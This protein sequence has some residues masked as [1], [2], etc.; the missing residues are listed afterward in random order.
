MKNFYGAAG[1]KT[2]ESTTSSKSTEGKAVGPGGVGTE[3]KKNQNSF[4][5]ELRQEQ[6]KGAPA[7]MSSEEL[8]MISRLP[9][10][11][12]SKDFGDK[13]Y[14]S[15]VYEVIRNMILGNPLN[16]LLAFIPFAVI[17][18]YAKWSAESVFILNCIALVPLA[19]LLGDF[20][21]EV[22][23]HTNQTIGGLINATFGN[24]FEVVVAIQALMAY[25]IRIVQSSMLGSVLSN[26]L[27]V[28]G[29][30]FFFGGMKYKEQT[31]N[32]VKATATMGLLGLSCIAMTLPTPFAH[33]YEADDEEAL[34]I[35][36]IA[37]VA[38]ICMYLQLL[39]FQLFTHP[40]LFEDEDDGDEPE[41][42]FWT[43]VT[44]LFIVTAIITELSDY[45]VQS[46]DGFCES[47]GLSRT[48]VGIIIIPIVGNAIEHFTAVSFAMKNKLDL[49][50]EI[51]VGSSVQISIFVTPFVVVVGWFVDRPLTLNFPHYET[52]LFALSVLIVSSCVS[53]SRT[54]W[55]EGSLL[56]TLYVMIAI[57]F[58]F[59][60][61]DTY[62][63]KNGKIE[64]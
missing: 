10:D 3:N 16:I 1:R 24:A 46:I 48:F 50:M 28:L 57:G 25:E 12:S 42:P 64:E 26:L 32:S 51:C 49:A 4:R 9:G 59:E 56:V 22:A 53:N 44:C 5:K 13:V 15:T 30:S 17:S 41:M 11:K 34:S 19:A 52:F 18:H 21:E 38:L 35:S 58:W 7:S 20:T 54:N 47:S 6:W 63:L 29:C 31:F 43:S 14:D 39:V 62:Q 60:K 55:L 23:T 27:L 61:V 33:Y 36:R 2:T 8:P 37:A 45:L 40:E